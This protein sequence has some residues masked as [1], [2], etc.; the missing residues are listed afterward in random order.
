MNH[1]LI[2]SEALI[3][4]LSYALLHSLWQGALIGIALLITL[5]A[6]RS[7]GSNAR[8]ALS[9][10]ALFF[11]LATF[12]WTFASKWWALHAVHPL[13]VNAATITTVPTVPVAHA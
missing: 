10:S 1:T 8:Y 11:V 9:Y 12:L 4:S 5:K 7:L 6:F 13:A 2:N 3:Q